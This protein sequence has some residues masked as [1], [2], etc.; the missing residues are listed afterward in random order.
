MSSALI[1]SFFS[2]SPR[3]DSVHGSAPH[4]PPLSRN[5]A[6]GAPTL[7]PPPT[8]GRRGQKPRPGIDVAARVADDR[9]LAG[10]PRGGVNPYDPLHRDGEQP[11]RGGLPKGVL[12]RE[13]EIRALP[14]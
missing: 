10:R 12:R 4:R 13:G 11:E 8:G 7:R 2:I 14:E 5:R 3:I 6:G 9:R 1:E